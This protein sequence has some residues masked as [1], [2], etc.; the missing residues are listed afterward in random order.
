MDL[1]QLKYFQTVARTEHMTKAARELHI[2]QPALSVM[3]ARLE[4]DLGVKLFDRVGRQIRLN[5]FGKAYLKHVDKALG[6][7]EEGRREMEDMAGL[8]QGSILLATTTLHRVA[9]YLGPFLSLHPHVNFRITQAIT[10]EV[11]VELLDKGEIDFC[12]ATSLIEQ[13][14]ICN[15][16]LQTEEI[17]L[18]VPST[19]RFA[20]RSSIRLS[21]VAND[22]FINLK[23]GYSFRRI[24]DEF[25]NKAGFIPN[26]IC[27]GDEPA[28]ISS[29]VRAGL[30]VAFLPA[31]AKR[32][33]PPL[34]LL[35][36]EEPL[37]QWTPHLIW[38]EEHYLSLAAQAFRKFI[39]G[40]HDT[41]QSDF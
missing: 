37:C 30:G 8:E 22:P 16:P 36:I 29:L 35:H 40:H 26:L 31:V 20:E 11:M 14:G 6:A 5:V 4:E 41:A 17:M 24:T 39:M 21:E 25:C 28:A 7:L 1:L 38:L 19:H 3:I 27:E 10:E 9:D 18:A 13:P 33:L 34:H 2:A 32:E 15:L 12:I 23:E